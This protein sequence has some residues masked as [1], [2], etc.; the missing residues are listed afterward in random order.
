M[1]TYCEEDKLCTCEEKGPGNI[2]DELYKEQ[3]G[4]NLEVAV[5]FTAP[6]GRTNTD[7][8]P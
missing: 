4:Y 5:S 7:Y 1:H 6:E 2:I 3:A 8:L